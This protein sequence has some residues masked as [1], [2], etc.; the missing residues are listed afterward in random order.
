V[1]PSTGEDGCPHHTLGG[2]EADDDVQHLIGEAA[3]D[4]EARRWLLCIWVR[5]LRSSAAA[6]SI[7]V[8]VKNEPGRLIEAI[9]G[10]VRTVV[11]L[12]R[13]TTGGGLERQERV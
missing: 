9:K 7:S 13:R 3:D 11:A 1:A 10:S 6:A 2:E 8:G 5:R 12:A 4:V